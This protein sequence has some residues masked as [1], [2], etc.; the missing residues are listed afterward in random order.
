MK[1][2]SKLTLLSLIPLL[3]F[4][5]EQTSQVLSDTKQEIIELK[6][7]QIEQKE[8]YNKYDWLSD[9]NLNGSI[10][11]D[12][13]SDT[14]RDFNLS[15]SQDIYKFGGITSQIDYAKQ[16]K[17]ME[18]LSLSISTKEDLD[19]IFSTLLDAKINEINLEQ[20]KLNVLNSE[21]DIRSKKSEYKAG[22]LGISDLNDAI[23]T[24][25]T[26][27]DTQKELALAKL[28]NI[29]TIKKYTSKNYKNIEIPSVKLMSK[30][31]YL[32][33][34]TSINYIKVE[35][36][37]NNSLYEIKKSDYLPSL[38]VTGQYGYQD[39]S[40]IDGDDYYNYGLNLSMP[41]SYTSSN[42]IEQTRLDYLISKKE[43]NDEKVSSETTYDEK[44]LTIKSYEERILLAQNDIKLY[45]ELLEVNEEEYKAGY[46]TIDDVDTIRNSKMIRALDIKLY[47]LN[48][49]KQILELYFNI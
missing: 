11:K 28:V 12:Q 10:K 21:I 18:S 30:E 16:L 40:T 5:S 47:K 14:T 43:L 34:A 8:Q 24:K 37:V 41:L 26:L 17:K 13:D 7:K 45:D 44:V 9:I 31:I 15:I 23:M 33:N 48:I 29:N 2:L 3:A 38:A 1:Q 4:S 22:E 46:K 42:D 25:N 35:N 19:T 6:Q 27:S 32:Q 20:N 36:E 49:Q 39:S